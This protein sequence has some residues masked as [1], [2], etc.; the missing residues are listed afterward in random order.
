MQDMLDLRQTKLDSIGKHWTFFI[1]GIRCSKCVQKLESLGVEH[2][3]IKYSRFDQ[4]KSTLTLGIVSEEIS[5][6][7]VVGWIGKKGYRSYYIIENIE[8]K[9]RLIQENRAWLLRLAV[10]FFFASNIMLFSI[11]IYAGADR[12]WEHLFS[13]ISGAMFI[14]VFIYSAL[15]FYKNSYQSLREG[16]FSAD[17]AITIAFAWGSILSYF[18]LLRGNQ[19]FYFDSSASF[20]FLI[21]FARYVLYRSQKSIES[22]LNPSL[23]FKNN[24]FYQVERAGVNHKVQFDQIVKGDRVEVL[25]TQ[26]I[27]VDG[28]LETQNCEI[29]TSIFSGESLPQCL[30]RGASVKAGMLVQAEKLD[31]LT[32]SSFQDSELYKLFEGVLKN[33]QVK[34]KA[35]TSAEVYSQRLLTVVS[36]GSMA[37]LFWF[38]LKDDWH[39]GFFRALALFT[40][41]CPC[42]L[43]LAIPLASITI[44]KRA[45]SLGIIAKTPLLFEKLQNVDTIVF[46]KTG[47][48]T[49][50]YLD[51]A[52]WSTQRPTDDVLKIIL[53]LEEKSQH[54][55]A[56]S[57]SKILNEQGLAPAPLDSWT[58][59]VGEGVCGKLGS[60][61]YRIAKLDHFPSDPTY[62]GF[63]FYKDGQALTSI[64][65]RD[66]LRRESKVVIDWLTRNNLKVEI[67]SGD[68]RSVVESVA[69]DL[70]LEPRN[71][72]SEMNPNEKSEK[73]KGMKSLMIGD[74]HNDSLALSSAYT[75][76]AI[77]GSAETSL[78]AA[79]AYCQQ[80]GLA[81]LPTLFLLSAFYKK[82]VNQ[83]IFLSLAYNTIAGLLAIFGYVNPL[84]AAVLM[85]INSLVVISATAMAKPNIE[86]EP[87]WKHCIS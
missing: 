73:L 58:E 83:N 17:V 46:D 23:L 12:E 3:T 41:A 85:P 34:T 71:C 43:A 55:L 62:T 36:V 2:Q 50:G 80:A 42:A 37:L 52:G 75:S 16:K 45:A 29:D 31:L 81:G 72:F 11:A 22:E 19:I 56:K 64:Y 70:N 78:Q 27:P 66:K 35:Q 6:E 9:N 24:P 59:Q 79:D 57:I 14:P 38:G 15:P 26:M 1:E 18:N 63:T 65:F 82:L 21:L 49:E 61:V 87:V 84:M 74:G 69:Q 48:L 53:A 4:G 32:T 51:F 54:P 76:L 33:R 10:T 28:K 86:E 13:L 39:E 20:L 67:F 44:L 40:I 7:D 25:P 77:S 47:T 8:V 30:Y 68:R 60:H 5:P